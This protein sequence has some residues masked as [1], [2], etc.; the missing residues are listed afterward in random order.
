M[1]GNYAQKL[2]ETYKGGGHPLASGF[3]MTLDQ[4]DKYLK[5]AKKNATMEA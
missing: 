1:V 4:F 3:Y 2:A 5:T